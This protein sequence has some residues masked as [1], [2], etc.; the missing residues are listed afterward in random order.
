MDASP[1]TFVPLFKRTLWGG[2][3]L[4]TLLGKPIGSGDDYAESWEIVDHEDDQSVVTQGPW[5]GRSLADLFGE[6]RAWL[7]GDAWCDRHPDAKRFPLL[8]KFLDCNRVLSVQVH[9]DD[10]FGKTMEVP[11]LGKTEAWVVLHADPG[12]LIYAGLRAGIDRAALAEHISRGQTESALHCFAPAVGDC[13]FIPAGTVHALGAGLVIAEIQQSSDTTFRLFDWN[14]VDASGQSR[15]LHI[16]SSLAVTDFDRGPVSPVTPVVNA[17]SPDG[18]T[19][20]TLVRC[21]KFTLRRATWTGD[22]DH[23]IGGDG[24]CHMLSVIAGPMTLDAASGG[25]SDLECPRGQSVLLPAASAPVSC[26]G[27]RSTV[28][29]WMTPGESTPS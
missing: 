18:V 22:G 9:P 20:E 27:Q 7:M 12:S 10:A 3:R 4:G 6:H 17:G 23:V 1:L 21:D 25:A 28:V 26:R 16:E 11:D 24:Q 5:A 19:V 14:R 8:L 2:R 29:L 13:V 15:P